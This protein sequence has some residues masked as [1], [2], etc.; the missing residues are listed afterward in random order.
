M[1]L[2]AFRFEKLFEYYNA[3]DKTKVTLDLNG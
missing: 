3:S 2:K 1:L